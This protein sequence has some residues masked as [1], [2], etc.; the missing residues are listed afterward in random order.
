MSL[1]IH[2]F[3]HIYCSNNLTNLFPE[4]IINIK[5]TNKNYTK[6]KQRMQTCITSSSSG[7][8]SWLLICSWW[9][10][11]LDVSTVNNKQN[12]INKHYLMI[13]FTTDLPKVS[14]VKN[15]SWMVTNLK[16]VWFSFYLKNMFPSMITES[17]KIGLKHERF[18]S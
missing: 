14:T 6:T 4:R 7:S 11:E 5:K 3:T 1:F 18:Y 2:I 9:S 10:T 15:M 8:S 13:V 16:L 12:I 17:T